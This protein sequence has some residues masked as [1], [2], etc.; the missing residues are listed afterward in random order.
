LATAPNATASASAAAV[1][2]NEYRRIR[3]IVDSYP[4]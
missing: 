4:L 3:S 1:N 2:K